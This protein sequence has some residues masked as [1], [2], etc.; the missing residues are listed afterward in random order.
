MKKRWKAKPRRKE[1]KKKE[2]KEE[3]ERNRRGRAGHQTRGMPNT[4]F[5][6]GDSMTSGRILRGI[7]AT[8]AKGAP[9]TAP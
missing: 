7:L 4:P 5:S 8:A 9:P 3:K 6:T 2:R 1:E